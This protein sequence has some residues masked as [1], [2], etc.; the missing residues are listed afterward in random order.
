MLLEVVGV[1]VVDGDGWGRE[2][3]GGRTKLGERGWVT[4]KDVTKAS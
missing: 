2:R 1:Q 3:G 4:K